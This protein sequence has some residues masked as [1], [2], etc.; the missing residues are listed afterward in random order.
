MDPFIGDPGNSQALNPYTYILNNPL[1]G[2]DP[3][4]YQICKGSRI[5]RD[6]CSSFPFK[7]GNT[8]PP[9]RPVV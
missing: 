6:D 9:G 1:S 2:T 3:T 4:G 5:D 7:A 8:R